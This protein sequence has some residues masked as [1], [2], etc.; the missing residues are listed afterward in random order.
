MNKRHFE[1]ASVTNLYISFK[2][3][4]EFRTYR[5]LEWI[6]LYELIFTRPTNKSCRFRFPVFFFHV[7]SGTFLVLILL[8]MIFALAL[9]CDQFNIISVA[10][11][12]RPGSLSKRKWLIFSEVGTMYNVHYPIVKISF[13][14]VII[15]FSKSQVS[16]NSSSPF[17]P[18]FL[19][20]SFR[21]SK[22]IWCVYVAYCI[23]LQR[24]NFD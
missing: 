1:F 15:Q 20:N 24:Y 22:H 12:I 2:F 10:H 6:F 19:R 14:T 11:H 18:H 21:I 17:S 23:V 13:V 8:M 4:W 9:L 16:W 3:V 7:S 5:S